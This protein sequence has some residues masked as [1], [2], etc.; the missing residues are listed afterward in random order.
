MHGPSGDHEAF[1]IIDDLAGAGTGWKHFAFPVDQGFHF[2][3]RQTCRSPLLGVLLHLPVFLNVLSAIFEKLAGA[4]AILF[5]VKDAELDTQGL[6]H[7]WK[8]KGL[9]VDVPVAGRVLPQAREVA[10]VLVDLGGRQEG[11]LEP[12]VAPRR[13]NVGL[14]HRTPVFSSLCCHGLS[15]K[16]VEGGLSQ[17][18]ELLQHLQVRSGG[19][20]LD[21]F[22]HRTYA[23][24]FVFPTL[25]CCT[26][27]YVVR[28]CRH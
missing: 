7:G 21:I 15:Y 4:L 23:H 26:R 12:Y 13:Q 14:P 1:R 5:V 9:D 19:G 6:L 10:V 18:G 28:T 27:T 24:F 8:G 16:V 22:Y 3:R 20:M 17:V 2:R 11:G 25:C